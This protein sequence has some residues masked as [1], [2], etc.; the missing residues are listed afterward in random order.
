MTTSRQDY[1]RRE[2]Q[3]LCEKATLSSESRGRERNE[4]ECEIRTCFQRDR[5]RIIHSKAFRRLKHKTQV[6]LKPLD[7]HYRTRL[8]HTLEVGQIARTISRALRLNEDLVE[9]ICMGH[10]LGH[11]PFGHS[12]EAALKDIHPG[13]F[14]HPAQSLRVVE[15]LEKDGLG[16]NLTHEVRDG[17]ASHSKGMGPIIPDDKDKLPHTLEGQVARI[18]DIV[19]YVNHD[20]DDAI[21]AGLLTEDSLPSDI[22]AEIGRGHSRR[23]GSMVGDVIR[24]TLEQGMTHVTMSGVMR[25]KTEQ[26]RAF[27]NSNVYENPISVAQFDKA[28]RLLKQLYEYFLEHPEMVPVPKHL[29]DSLDEHQAVCDYLAGMTDDYAIA[30]FED[31]FL[32]KSWSRGEFRDV[33]S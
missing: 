33:S 28:K 27:L 21:R 13:G 8:T 14:S 2:R 24:A 26:L 9:A 32:P 23:I 1:E 7:D 12:G 20:I 10:D 17:I 31:L 29:A 16:L 19:A 18:S 25:E 4:P 6:F 22:A 30:I 5:D 15:Q 3:L 11:T